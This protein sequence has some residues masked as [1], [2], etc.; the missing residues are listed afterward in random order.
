MANTM[1]NLQIAL[2]ED[3]TKAICSSVFFLMNPY[4]GQQ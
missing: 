1:F 4:F 3:S 2:M